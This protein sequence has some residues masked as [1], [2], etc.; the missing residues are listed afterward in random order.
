MPNEIINKEL[1]HT[2]DLEKVRALRVMAKS[3]EEAKA[4]GPLLQSAMSAMLLQGP[5]GMISSGHEV[6]LGHN[7]QWFVEAWA[8]VTS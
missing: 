4:A 2:G 5:G 7:H 1:V 3:K 6:V 8:V